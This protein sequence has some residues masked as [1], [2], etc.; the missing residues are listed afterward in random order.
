M[1]LENT[2]TRPV[3]Q[4]TANPLATPGEARRAGGIRRSRRRD[5]PPA[6]EKGAVCRSSWPKTLDRAHII[7]AT[8]GKKIDAE[9]NSRVLFP[10]LL[11]SILAIEFLR[12]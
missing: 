3:S 1:W 12:S 4:S 9:E 10:A 2:T 11:G 6:A 8:K 7:L 5:F